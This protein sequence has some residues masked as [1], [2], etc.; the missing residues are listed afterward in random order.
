MV[1]LYAHD[2]VLTSTNLDDLKAAMQHI[3]DN[4]LLRKLELYLSKCKM[5]KFRI[6]GRGHYNLTDNFMFDGVQIGFVTEFTYWE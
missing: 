1:L 6:K 5:M 4:L 3:K 2:I